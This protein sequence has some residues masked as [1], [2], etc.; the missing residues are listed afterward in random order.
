MSLDPDTLVKLRNVA[1]PHRLGL[2]CDI[3]GTLS[4]IA[5]TPDAARVDAACLSALALLLEHVPLVAAVT[6]RAPLD[7]RALVGIAGML[8]VGNH[9]LERWVDGAVVPEP[10]VVPFAEAVTKTLDGLVAHR[11]PEGVILENKGVTASVHYRQ[12]ADHAAAEALLGGLLRPLAAEHG[13]RLLPGRM[14]FE[15]RPPVALNKGTAISAL[16]AEHAL[17]AA[18]FIG[19]DVTDVDGFKALHA[20]RAA[21]AT[22]LAVGVLSP[23]T[24]AVVREQ[25]DV[26]V[27]G[28]EGV[29]E[30]LV[31]LLDLRRS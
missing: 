9:G 17:E 21:G 12:A 3:D 8:Y 30:L 27:S 18:I 1:Q 11:L 15:I 23:E 29:A 5:P 22:T 25:A 24:P 6:G 13:L 10:A 2:F 26:T 16:I 4:R 14:I 31:Q 7:A 19:D 20:A 28:V